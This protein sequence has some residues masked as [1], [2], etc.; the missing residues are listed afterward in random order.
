MN[1]AEAEAA[2]LCRKAKKDGCVEPFERYLA[3]A[4]A[5]IVAGS[6]GTARARRAELV[7]L[8]SHDVAIR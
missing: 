3:D 1:R 4:Y 5:E 7:V 2:R 6:T 8:V